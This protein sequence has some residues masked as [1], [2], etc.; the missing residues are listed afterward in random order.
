MS[1]TKIRIKRINAKAIPSDLYHFCFGLLSVLYIA[2]VPVLN[3][4]LGT[5]IL[6]GFAPYSLYYCIR[7]IGRKKEASS[8]FFF[9]FYLYLIYRSDGNIMRIILCITAFINLAGQMSGAIR[10]EKIRSVVEGF[11]VLN[12]ILIIIQSFSYYILHNTIQYIPRALIYEEYRNSWVFNTVSG[13]YRP[14]ALFLEPS[15]FAQFC[16]F[17]LISALFP[18]DGVVNKKRALIIGVGCILSTSGMGIALTAG[19]FAWYLF[20]NRE[21][22]DKK[23]VMIIKWIPIALVLLFVLSRMSFFQTALQRVFSNV[24]GYNAIVGRTHNWNDAVGKM[25][26]KLLWLGYGDSHNYR[27]YLT[28][29][30]DSI[31]KYGIISVILEGISLLYLMI[32]KRNNFVWLCCI[33]FAALFCVAHITNF[34]SQVFYF[35][36]ILSEVCSKKPYNNPFRVEDK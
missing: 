20:L 26:G 15:H 34:A 32:K 24:G 31:Y 18:Y 33:V 27:W 14:S 30:A 5:V 10:A 11:A 2:N 12:S 3:I 28:G 4:S 35:G 22:F 29:L 6:I 19:V 1:L 17:A 13:L 21:K 23:I 25:H 16:V 7:G 9:I 36:F 8:F